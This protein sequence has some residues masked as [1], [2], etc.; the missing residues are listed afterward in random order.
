MMSVSM[1]RI[2]VGEIFE[3]CYVDTDALQDTMTST[4]QGHDATGMRRNDVNGCI[5]AQ[6]KG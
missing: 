2:G 4:A 6:H 3:V 1:Y 5:G